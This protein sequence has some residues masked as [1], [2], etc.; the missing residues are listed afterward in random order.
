MYFRYIKLYKGSLKEG[1]LSSLLIFLVALTTVFGVL[2]KQL[3]VGVYVP[4]ASQKKGTIVI[5]AGHGGE[6]SGTV[7][8]NGIL[9]KDVNLDIARLV[10]AYLEEG[11]YSVVYTRTDDRL[12]YKPE[13]NIKGIRKISDLKN[14]VEIAEKYPDA[15]FISLHVNS[16]GDRKYSGLQVYYS[17]NAEDSRILADNIQSEVKN[18]LQQENNR[19]IKPGDK[20][21]VLKNLSTPAVL[22]ECGFLSNPEE[23]EKLSE[24]EYQKRLSFSIVCG[25]IKYMEEKKTV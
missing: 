21:Y 22:I 24:K 17:A 12:L 23:C 1:I 13:E 10:G 7:G 19:K 25:I 5:D 4:T 8:V 11:G 6:D 16:Y 20:I 18:T 2:I 9:E 14:R 15:V 3:Y